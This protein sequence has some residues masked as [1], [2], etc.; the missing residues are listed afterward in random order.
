[1]ARPTDYT[2]DDG[3]G[4]QV[5]DDITN[6]LTEGVLTTNK[7]SS[8]P[9]YAVAGTLFIQGNTLKVATSSSSSGDT[10]I[11]DITAANLGLISTSTT[12]LN[13]LISI[14]RPVNNTALFLSGGSSAS[15]GASIRLSGSQMLGSQNIIDFRVDSTI[16]LRIPN[17]VNLLLAD[18]ASSIGYYNN[19]IFR[20]HRNSGIGV[21]S[22]FTNSNTGSNATDGSL[23]GINASGHTL[24]QN[25]DG[26]KHILFNTATSG[27]FMFGSSSTAQNDSVM[28]IT[29]GAN[30]GQ[31]PCITFNHD[32][33]PSGSEILGGFRTVNGSTAELASVTARHD[34]TSATARLVMATKAASGSSTSRM[35]ITK[36][37][38]I[39]INQDASNT[40]GISTS[41]T[42][43][44]FAFENANCLYISRGNST[45]MLNLNTNGNG[46]EFIVFRK[47]GDEKG[48]IEVTD[49]GQVLT[50]GFSDYRLKENIVD[51]DDGITRLKK[52]KPKRF[53]FIEARENDSSS[54]KTLDGFLAHEVFEV[55]PEAVVG[56]KDGAKMQKLD[57]TKL[58]TVTVAA[59]KEL[60]A[61][62]ETLES[63]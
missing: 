12:N 19:S 60:I 63:K 59:L 4:A 34:G 22:H 38:H 47:S 16:K 35:V 50:V 28:H 56:E 33:T 39:R 53:N 43:T 1:M 14:T 21:I 30:T 51:I 26:A 41:D 7:G 18:D 20:G 36:E 11:G 23:I 54:Y 17:S 52:L 6:V 45:A 3:T 29:S 27:K 8:R 49:Q 10:T 31:R 46:G 9:S 48:S 58:I 42:T 55:C 5:L 37:G 15:D 44:G 61:R 32:A 2:I 25:Q 57:S 40:P 62:V 24:I 13:T